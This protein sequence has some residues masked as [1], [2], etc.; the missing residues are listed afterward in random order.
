MAAGDSPV[1]ICNVGLIDGLGQDPISS[2]DDPVKAAILCKQ[3]YD[4]LRREM[5][6]QFP[7]NFARKQAKLAAD[8]TA[9]LFQYGHAYPLPADYITMVNLPDNDMAEW[10][11]FG[12]AL[13]TDEGAPLNVIYICDFEDPVRFDP[14]FVKCLGLSIAS[15]LAIP[16]LQD[17][18][19]R[20]DLEA[21]WRA[22]L[23]TAQSIASQENSPQPWDVDVLLRSRR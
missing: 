3:R 6:R 17:K 9:P 23:G 5:L 7:W 10:Q 20:D 11:V 2:L 12:N 8:V 4:G 14:L 15:A 18:R 19:L 1:S 13:Y 22:K 16:L 21:L